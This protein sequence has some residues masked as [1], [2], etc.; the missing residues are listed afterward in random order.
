M[1]RCD[2]CQNLFTRAWDDELSVAE[3]EALET[4]W[5]SCSACRRAYDEYA[6]TLELVQALPRPVVSPDF[7]ARVLS[8]AR[9]REAET[10]RASRLG[11][12][13]WAFGLAP[14]PAFALAAAFAVVVGVGAV[15]RFAPRSTAP[16]VATNDLPA[17]E[18]SAAPAPALAPTPG[19]APATERASDVA[20]V[21]P[22]RG[23]RAARG[24]RAEPSAA[25]ADARVARAE[26]AESDVAAAPALAGAAA[27]ASRDAA[28]RDEVAAVP[29][30]LF[31]H[32]ADVELVLDPVRM[33]RERG[34]GYTPVQTTVRGEAAS[35]TF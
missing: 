16:T 24:L 27:P 12:P 28:A 5:T 22:A 13:G 23:D 3:R 35:I 7:A 10:K 11:R 1:M 25:S 26:R 9:R 15:V 31:D 32:T 17:V 29:D 6:R 34:R 19:T 33:R 4:H 18:S 30:S 2:R 21:P 14:R 20:V 8:E